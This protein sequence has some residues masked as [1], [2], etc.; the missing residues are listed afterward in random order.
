MKKLIAGRLGKSLCGIAALLAAL[1][2]EASA[3]LVSSGG[4]SF[5]SV[6]LY[7]SL[8]FGGL[9]HNGDGGFESSELNGID[10]ASNRAPRPVTTVN[11]TL[12]ADG[13]TLT[14]FGQT[15]WS[16]FYAGR[17]LARMTVTSATNTA[18]YYQVAG[19]GSATSVQFFDPSAAAAYATF[20][21]HV[22]GV[23]S[24]PS[25]AGQATGR[26]DFGASTNPNVTWDQLFSDPN[27]QLNSITELGPGTFTYNLP[28]SDLGTRINL[29][30]WSSAFTQV[31]P[32]QAAAGS[33]FSLSADYSN[34]FVLETVGLF[35][36]AGDPVPDWTL[37][38]L[39]LG[40]TVFDQNGRI[41]AIAPPP[42]TS[43]P[44]PATNTLLLTG[45]AAVGLVRSRRKKDK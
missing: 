40:E 6:P 20:T 1:G 41:N 23:S 14:S 10:Y 7:R 44:E 28:I 30:Y 2:S 18:T 15:A 24:N 16:G 37:T 29:F 9:D 22:S 3:D 8:V 45:A 25:T 5:A 27:N 39:N 36:S 11:T 33:S 34:T 26:L 42:G 21:W 35:N 43:T 12:S 31:N 4:G 17:N 19:T 13:A 38:D 32:G